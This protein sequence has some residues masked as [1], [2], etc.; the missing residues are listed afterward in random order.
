MSK[1]VLNV[2]TPR[3]EVTAIALVLHGGQ[4]NGTGPVRPT[5]LAVVRMTPFATSL[6]RAGGSRGLAVARLRYTVRGWN[7]AEQSPV[8]DVRWALDQLAARFP[9]VR[10]ALV[11]HSMGGRA[12]LYAADH[13]SVEAVVGLAPWI[14][15]GDP[16]EQ[17]AGRRILIAHGERDR[18]TSARQSAAYAAH[19]R[20]VAA[21]VTYVAIHGERHAMLRRAKLWHALTTGY[22]LDVMCGVPPAETVDASTADVLGKVLAGEASLVV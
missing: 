7:R 18:M 1:P 13:D 17:L 16:Y 20:T 2:E 22:V 12:A 14:E 15:A 10:V 8:P 11:G 3:G 6:E 5:Q 4:V 21:S 9:G 19:A